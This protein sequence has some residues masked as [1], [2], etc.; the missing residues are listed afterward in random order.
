M[1]EQL[2]HVHPDMDLA[3]VIATLAKEFLKKGSKSKTQGNTITKTKNRGIPAA[4]RRLVMARAK[5]RCEY[6]DPKTGRQCEST[7]QIEID[8]RHP[9]CLGGTHDPNN[10][11]CLC[12]AHNSL[13]SE[14]ILGKAKSTDNQFRHRQRRDLSARSGS[15][16]LNS[17]KQAAGHSNTDGISLALRSEPDVC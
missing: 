1:A 15:K 7:Y 13:M 14:Q 6:R 10:L 2:S 16:D 4:T 17:N 11:R 12:K 8:H 5:R 9:W 3:K